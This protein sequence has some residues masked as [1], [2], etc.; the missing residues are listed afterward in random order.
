MADLRFG[1]SK[2]PGIERNDTGAFL[3]L[4]SDI[5]SCMSKTDHKHIQKS[6]TK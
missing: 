2:K 5:H 6:E 3:L 1:F 4:L